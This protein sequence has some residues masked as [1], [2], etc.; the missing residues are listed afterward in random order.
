MTPDISIIIPTFRRPSELSEA[1]S[2][3]L[4]QTGA[5]IELFVVD[6]SAEG[7]ARRVVEAINDNRISYI[8]NP[9]PTGGVPSIVR[10]LAMPLARAKLIHFLDDDDIVPNGHYAR[11]LARFAK[12]PDVG[13]VFGQIQPFGSG[14]EPQL[15]QERKFFA[16]AARLARLCRRT[17]S[18]LS[19]VS[20]Q[21]FRHALL[22]CSAGVVRRD[23]VTAIGGFDPSLRIMEDAD[24]YTFIMRRFAVDFI[25]DVT[26]YYRISS[27][28]SLMHTASPSEELI[29]ET[30]AN[31]H[32]ARIRTL[33]KYR[34]AFGLHELLVL[35]VFARTVLR[36]L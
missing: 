22:V 35:K 7:S 2:S 29:A 16:E 9:N 1:I 34:S 6:D 23:C 19:F 20:S 10:N 27:N 17:G 3:V 5:R 15:A 30:K 28:H 13:L 14:P 11:V 32:T 8:Q 4:G 26:L 12:R 25:D 31:L 24:F 18:R 21:L 36:V 33:G